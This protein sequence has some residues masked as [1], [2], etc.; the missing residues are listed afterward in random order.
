MCLANILATMRYE[1]SLI[2][3]QSIYPPAFP[4]YYSLTFAVNCTRF[5]GVNWAQCLLQRITIHLLDKP[6][7]RIRQAVIRSARVQPQGVARDE[8]LPVTCSVIEAWRNGRRHCEHCELLAGLNRTVRIQFAC[9]ICC[10]LTQALAGYTQSNVSCEATAN[11]TLNLL[12]V[13]CLD[14]YR[15]N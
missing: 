9:V 4:S 2:Y 5:M 12:I 15:R 3:Y 13:I 8:C 7:L 11:N 1:F 10:S 6:F 14:Y